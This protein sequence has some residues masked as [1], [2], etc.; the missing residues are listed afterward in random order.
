VKCNRGGVQA[1]PLCERRERRSD[2][3]ADSLGIE[4][5][6]SH[7]IPECQQLVDRDAADE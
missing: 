5:R 6:L 7:R 4:E 1:K 3:P 2:A